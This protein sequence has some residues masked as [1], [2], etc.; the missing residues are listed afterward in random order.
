[1][2]IYSFVFPVLFIVLYIFSIFLFRWLRKLSLSLRISFTFADDACM[3]VCLAILLNWFWDLLVFF[4]WN[5]DL[6]NSSLDSLRKIGDGGR[7][8]WEALK[9]STDFRSRVLEEFLLLLQTRILLENFSDIFWQNVLL[10]LSEFNLLHPPSK[11]DDTK[12]QAAFPKPS[13]YE[14]SFSLL[15][16]IFLFLIKSTIYIRDI[17]MFFVLIDWEF[18][19]P[20]I[21][22]WWVCPFQKSEL[23]GWF[24]TY[25]I[26]EE[27]KLFD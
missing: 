14:I 8:R 24:A 6:L 18:L 20:N 4:L 16:L 13:K 21:D 9:N 22:I 25:R 5:L 19:L 26:E 3:Y 15:C 7:E 17:S 2:L 10:L 1:M 27:L 12:V 23:A 11:I